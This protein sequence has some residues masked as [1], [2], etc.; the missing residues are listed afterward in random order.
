MAVET[1]TLSN[2]TKGLIAFTLLVIISYLW[3]GAPQHQPQSYHSFADTLS[4]FGLPNFF[5]V[6]SNIGFLIVGLMGMY[7]LHDNW[8][9]KEKF[10]NPNEAIAFYVVFLGSVLLAF[11]SGFYHTAPDNITLMA[12]RFTMT[13]GFMGALSFIIIERIDL[14]WGL[15]LMPILLVI[16]IASVIYWI[17]PE[18]LGG[19][20]E[21]KPYIL[22]QGLSLALIFVIYF[23]YPPTYS[24]GKFILYALGFYVLAK[25]LEV[26]DQIIYDTLG[27]GLSGH[28]LKHIASA[29]GVYYILKYIQQRKAL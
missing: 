11:G 8:Q 13:V 24:H 27:V 29:V 14:K 23:L 4:L 7:Y 12:D 19:V 9:V 18:M 17:T 25:I 20:G 28:S 16:G 6:T 21:L 2:K 26:F 5:N 3:L 22:V 10:K 15:K 1:A